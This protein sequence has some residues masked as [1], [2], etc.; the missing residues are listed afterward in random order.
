MEEMVEMTLLQ[1]KVANSTS[2]VASEGYIAKV[3]EACHNSWALKS[4]YL[5]WAWYGHR[6]PP[7]FLKEGM[8]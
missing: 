1:P 6:H 3:R 5:E 7:P 2:H 4:T 8:V